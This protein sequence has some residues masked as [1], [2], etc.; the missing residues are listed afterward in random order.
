VKPKKPKKPPRQKPQRTPGPVTNRRKANKP[1]QPA[2][3]RNFLQRVPVAVVPILPRDE[4]DDPGPQD[5][6]AFGDAPAPE[7]IDE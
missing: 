3:G 7:D 6:S 5:V 1:L 2:R 4:F